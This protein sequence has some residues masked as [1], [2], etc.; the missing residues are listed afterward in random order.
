[1]NVAKLDLLLF[2]VLPY[3]AIFTA[4]A[5][6][7]YRLRKHPYTISSLSSQFLENKRHFW[8]L[9]LFH[10][11][12]IAALGGHIAGFLFP[13][14]VL[15][16]NAVPIRLYIL[17]VT[18][19]ALGTTAL[20]G[21]IL[22]ITRRG[23][24][25]RIRAVTTPA[26]WLLMGLLLVQV[27]SGVGIAL[28]LS[29]GAYWYHASAVPYLRSIMMLD[30][31]ASYV[32][33]MPWPIKLHVAGAWTLLLLL[34]FTR[35]IHMLATPVFY[36]FRRPQIVR[37]AANRRTAPSQPQ[38][39][40]LQ[41]ILAT[42]AFAL[43]FAVFGSLS[44]MMPL[45]RKQLALDPLRVSIAIA[46]P[47]LLGSLGRIPLG[48][49]TDRFGGR[50]VFSAVMAFSIIP[51]FVLGH[52][53]TYSA[54]LLFGFLVGIALASFS[55]GV[56]FVSG[57][58]PPQKQGMALGIY[59]AGNI[60]QSLAAYFSPLL[61]GAFG[62]VWGFQAFAILLG[63][64]LILF[65]IVA[66]DAAVP[67]QSKTLVQIVAPL[68]EVSSWKL[69]MYYFLTFGGFVAMSVFLPTYLTE[70]FA[71]KPTDAGLRTAG[72]VVITTAMRPFGGWLAD[73]LGGRTLLTIVFPLVFLASIPLTSKEMTLFTAGAIVMGLAIGLGNGAVFKL[74]PQYF[75]KAV[76]AVTGLVGAA[77]GL[78]GFFPPLMLGLLKR[79]SG[80]YTMGFLL[81][82]LFALA[83][84]LVIRPKVFALCLVPP[85]RGEVRICNRRNLCPVA[86]NCSSELRS[87]V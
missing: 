14:Q 47:I 86:A 48:M 36:I 58:Y 13:R 1:M 67:R 21:L 61:A 72:F 74:V 69:S 73:K 79:T 15:L 40:I 85:E 29:W 51:A 5:G 49:L 65:A 50:I 37:W 8:A 45:I 57:W 22:A 84:L 75:P 76:G 56:G 68:K 78:G 43:C 77:G 53:S 9:V 24:V 27:A 7:I 32:A 18:S 19:I 62:V 38:G 33:A 4:V 54:L 60:G 11:G 12:I 46:I 80:E 30:P 70:T 59:G 3:I 87:N 63:L 6:S 39:D 26:D 17:E 82:G 34:P 35:L 42:G 31:D 25:A 83:C 55:V 71:L 28:F 16:W 41:L 52:V 2:V 64:W 81:L 10:Y 23:L 66:R 44:A 20:I